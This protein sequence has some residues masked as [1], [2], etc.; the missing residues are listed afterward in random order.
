MSRPSKCS[1]GVY[2]PAA[3]EINLGC[4]T[5]NP[6]GL[7]A[8][9]CPIL[10]RSSSDVLVRYDAHETCK[11]CGGLR[12]YFSQQCM[13][14]GAAFPDDDVRS[15]GQETANRRQIGACPECGST[16]HYETKKKSEWECSDCRAKYKA[17]RL[18]SEQ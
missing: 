3:D 9:E 1:H 4:Q 16:V 7:G 11:S 5:C 15:R 2:W 12:T 8:G 17:P 10:P 6:D 18:E 14:C 13:H